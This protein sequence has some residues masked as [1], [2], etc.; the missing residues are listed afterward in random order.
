MKA[1]ILAAGIGS[2]LRPI[3]ENKPK[4][5]V[6]VAGKPIIAHQLES[7][8]EAGVNKVIVIVGHEGNLVKQYI[9]SKGFKNVKIIDNAEYAN[10][11][12]MYSLYLA[13]KELSG[14][15]FVLVNGDVVFDGRIAAELI[16]NEEEDLIAVDTLNYYE[17]SMKITADENKIITDISKKF[18]RR[19]SAGTSID[20]YK[21]SQK[22]SSILFS[23][24]A[25]II[26]RKRNKNEWTEVA[27]SRL[28]VKR[29]LVMRPFPIGKMAWVEIDNYD[30]LSQADKK[31]SLLNKTLGKKKVCFVDLD[32]T[33]YMGD[34]KIEGADLFLKELRERD[35][36]YYFLSNNSSK[37]K[38]EY[39]K[40]LRSMDIEARE[41]DILLST[42]GM[43]NYLK[44]QKIKKAYV[45]G[46][47]ALAKMVGDAGIENTVNNPECVI[48][49]YDTELTYEKLRV[50][51]LLIQKGTKYFAT[52]RDVVCPTA[53]GP[54]PDIG[55]FIEL[56]AKATGKYPMKIFGKPNFDMV[57]HILKKHRITG[58]G[59]I[60]VG[61]RLY[62]DMEL[63]KRANGSFILV[64]SGETKREDIE[65]YE[66]FPDM[67]VNDVGQIFR[68]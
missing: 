47:K 13:K 52:H 14:N 40:K 7:F 54:I 63:A 35:I 30:D 9:G 24:I 57:S 8:A 62:T 12:N 4:C 51:A 29:S 22:S 20:M 45:L 50:G 36:K 37:S 59:S 11:N 64:L 68:I 42:D 44:E 39:V 3:T 61:D 34:R 5:M 26:D 49:G 43:I 58:K 19:D 66:I 6:K 53:E 55:S 31:F 46:T 23:E 56:L 27:L 41:D 25:E 10:T 17:E 28:F 48:L 16:D 18:A 33:I 60:F 1:V 2:R 65:N 15:G 67:I 21:F 38:N 32:G